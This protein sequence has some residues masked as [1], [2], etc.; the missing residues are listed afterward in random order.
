MLKMNSKEERKNEKRHEKRRETYDGGGLG[1]GT[2]WIFHVAS[3][4]E[5]SSAA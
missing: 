2:W 3:D 5:C 4:K 1:R